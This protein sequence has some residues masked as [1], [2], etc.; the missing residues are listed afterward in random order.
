MPLRTVPVPDDQKYRFPWATCVVPEWL[1]DELRTR[2]PPPARVRPDPAAA[3]S[4]A[5]CPQ[6]VRP[7]LTSTVPLV[8][9][10]RT[11][12]C[13]LPPPKAFWIDGDGLVV[14][15]RMTLLYPPI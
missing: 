7:P 6:I 9:P 10:S 8:V 14:F 5:L 4:T 2:F 11:S 12:I 15:A 3:S 13:W 1:T